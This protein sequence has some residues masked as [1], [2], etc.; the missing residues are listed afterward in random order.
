MQMDLQMS[1]IK[2]DKLGIYRTVTH[3][4]KQYKLTILTLLTIYVV[5]IIMRGVPR[6]PLGPFG[7]S[8]RGLGR[9]IETSSQQSLLTFFCKKVRA[10]AA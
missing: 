1:D 9:G 3:K 2:V 6:G 4:P 7:R 5:G 10:C 8:V